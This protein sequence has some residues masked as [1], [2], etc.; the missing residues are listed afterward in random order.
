MRRKIVIFMV[1]LFSLIV[2]CSGGGGDGE[3]RPDRI[4]EGLAFPVRNIADLEE[5]YCF[6][7][8]P[9]D[10]EGNNEIHGGIDL[11]AKYSPGSSVTGRVHIIAPA[12]ALVE[13][14]IES[15]SG[16]GVETLIVVLKM[17]DYW[18]IICNFEPQTTDPAIFEE[19]RRSIAVREGQMVKRGDLIGELVIASVKSGSYPHL[20]FG[21]FYKHPDDTLDYIKA[22]IL[23]IRRSDGTDLAPTTGPGSPWEARDLNKETTLFCPYV[24]STPSAKAAYDS[25]AQIAA[26]GDTCNCI[27]AYNSR[28]GDCGTC[29]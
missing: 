1:M 22:N 19:Q 17:N 3:S 12:D 26:N 9:W 25:L 21:F 15:V 13:R 4:I 11:A 29:R 14:I 16:A 7:L 28:D 24:Y 20:H 8:Q 23:L 18:Y 27:C 2:G 5:F 10:R 6:G